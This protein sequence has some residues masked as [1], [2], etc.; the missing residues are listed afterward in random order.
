MS[1]PRARSLAGSSGWPDG[2]HNVSRVSGKLA[3]SKYGFLTRQVMRLI[4]WREGAPTDT[5]RDYEFTDWSA[6]RTFALA[7]A[8][9]IRAKT[10][11]AA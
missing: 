4:A 8:E 9:D 11:S 2:I 3:Y 10:T 7:M 1:P 5:R 6:V